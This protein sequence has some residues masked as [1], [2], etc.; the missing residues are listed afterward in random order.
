MR[1]IIPISSDEKLLHIEAAEKELSHAG[2]VF[3]RVTSGDT[4][5]LRRTGGV[6]SNQ[7]QREWILDP[8]YGASLED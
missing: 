2:V 7:A 1:L 5:D 4:E 6:F 3:H 8:I